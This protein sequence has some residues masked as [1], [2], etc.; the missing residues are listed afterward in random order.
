VASAPSAEV[1]V[2]MLRNRR[3]KVLID[4]CFGSV[5]LEHNGD[6]KSYRK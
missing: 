3:I 2:A 5:T 6:M 4:T 1:A